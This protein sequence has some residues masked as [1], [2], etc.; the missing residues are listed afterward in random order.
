MDRENS[1]FRSIPSES[2]P[3][4]QRVLALLSKVDNEFHS[5]GSAFVI[6]SAGLLMTA[7]HV[8]IEALQH[9]FPPDP[10]GCPGGKTFGLY[11]FF[12]AN[13]S[14]RP[15]DIG[16]L[17]PISPEGIRLQSE[18]DIGLCF[19]RQA[20]SRESGR[21]VTWPALEL[22]PGIPDIGTPIT[23]FGYHSMTPSVM[24]TLKE[25]KE[26]AQYTLS[27]AFADGKIQ[28]IHPE[29]RDRVMLNFPCFRT[30]ARFDSGMSGGPIFNPAGKVCGVICSSYGKREGADDHI[31]YGSLLWPSLGIE[32][33][34][35]K[36]PITDRKW[37][38]LFDLA[39]RGE[40]I[41]DQTLK[42]IVRIEQNKDSVVWGVRY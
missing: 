30:D 3:I 5:I 42:N 2:H 34:L 18:L 11:A 9:L 24:T 15:I 32:L 20:R 8:L 6:H 23:G 41:C 16:G 31:S 19:L 39:V 22:S 13:E 28:E 36:G 14:H 21:Q 17:W 7:G 35:P 29:Y 10:N 26:N 1:S 38:S 37:E 25:G 40:I 4:Q 27:R 12:E 33:I